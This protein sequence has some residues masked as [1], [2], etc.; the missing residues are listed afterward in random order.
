MNV[1]NWI[2]G[3]PIPAASDATIN[4]VNPADGS[5]IGTIPASG[6]DDVDAAVAAANAALPGWAATSLAQRLDI[7]DAIADGIE[8]RLDDFAAAET[9]D[10]GKP[11]T[12]SRSLDIPRAVRNFRFFADFTRSWRDEEHPMESGHNTT[13][14]KPVGVVGLITPWN[15]P[16]YLLTWKVAPALAMG[17]T[18]VAKPSELTPTT[19]SMLAEVAKDA[20][21]PDGVLNV[22]HGLGPDVGAPLTAHAD[23][24]AVSFTGGTATG[25]LVAAAAAPTFKKLSLELGGK[26]PT[27]IFDD[28]PLDQA[29]EG[30]MRAG[31]TNTGQ[32]CLCG[33][34]I[35]VQEG[36][37]DSFTKRLVAEVESMEP[38]NP[39][40]AATRIGP[41]VSQEHRV[42]VAGYVERARADGLTVHGGHIIDGSGAFLQP[43]VIVAPPQDHACVQEEIFGPVVTVQSFKDEAEAIA[44]A[45][46][47]A[48]GLAAS[49]WTPDT[50]TARRVA[51]A[52]DTGMV[53]VNDWLVRDLRVPFGGMKQSGVGREGGKWSLEFFSE[54]R[55][56]YVASPD[57]AKTS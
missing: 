25:R 53:W 51:E 28:C 15:L 38:G 5:V 6:A 49:V 40:D 55:N 46:D 21:L 42:K 57:P 33:S 9:R 39:M 14:R 52:L 36:L 30:A 35:L 10:S 56:I 47:V 26:N 18:I 4:N 43:A 48:Y 54:P 27:I 23:V 1:E 12:T 50:S 29:V 37:M 19:A 22:V 31:F 32:V 2:A 11:I 45:N 17:N 7:L 20:G 44:L 41:L 16:L 34:R 24:S 3:R 13:H 8:R